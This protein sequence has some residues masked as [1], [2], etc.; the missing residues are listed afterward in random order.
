MPRSS[1]QDLT[2][3]LHGWVIRLTEGDVFKGHQSARTVFDFYC[4]HVAAN[5]SEPR[6]F[7]RGFVMPGVITPSVVARKTGLDA[8]SVWRANNWLHEQGLIAV[9]DAC[10]PRYKYVYA[11][12]IISMDETSEDARSHSAGRNARSVMPA[13]RPRV[14]LDLQ[15]QINSIGHHAQ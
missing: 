12:E 3:Y 2:H 5:D 14:P 1:V 4:Q 10:G 6:G 9:T 11:I 7:V 15:E 8:K 13:R